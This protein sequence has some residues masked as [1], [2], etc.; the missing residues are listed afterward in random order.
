MPKQITEPT[1]ASEIRRC[2][3]GRFEN[4][5]TDSKVPGLILR[6]S[7][8]G[9]ASWFLRYR[10]GGR[11]R[12][13]TIG[14]YPVW[15]IAEAR[16]KAKALRRTVDEGLDVAVEKQRRNIEQKKAQT[17]ADV[18]AHYFSI[19]AKDIAPSTLLARQRTYEKYIDADSVAIFCET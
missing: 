13:I 12:N 8:T 4:T 5:I 1:I 7:E 11:R 16:D 10:I 19:V 15:G 3:A 18:A 9:T 17:V 2:R 14:K 6:I